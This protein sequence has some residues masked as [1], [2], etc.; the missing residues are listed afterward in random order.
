M[1]FEQPFD[2]L[3][4][5]EQATKIVQETLQQPLAV[6]RDMINYG[7]NLLVRCQSQTVLKQ[8][9]LVVLNHLFAHGLAMLDAAHEQLSIGC[10]PSAELQVRS[11]L[12]AR[13]SIA[14]IL[15]AEA[16]KRARYF[17][18]W[19]KL[20]E[21]KE[22]AACI[23]G[24]TP[25]ELLLKEMGDDFKKVVAPLE[26][27]ARSNVK[28][29]RE[30]L[31]KSENALIVADYKKHRSNHWAA[32]FGI[33]SVRKLAIDIGHYIEYFYLYAP[34][35]ATMHGTGK[36]VTITSEFAETD[37][38][39]QPDKVEGLLDT[40][41]TIAFGMLSDVLEHYRIA[42]I[43]TTFVQKADAWKKANKQRKPFKL[44]I[45]YVGPS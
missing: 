45:K 38:L 15:S 27:A 8:T 24:E 4:D 40:T 17:R 1:N 36:R 44:N 19:Q 41:Y 13:L 6:L 26:K 25:Y 5:R 2:A 21:L 18:V 7:T 32:P 39:R 12:E 31:D 14:F 23:P 3:L 11:M 35:S 37:P 29:I 30:W 28:I 20:E 16:E 33:T 10:A 22:Q 9:E 42:E 43:S 34:F